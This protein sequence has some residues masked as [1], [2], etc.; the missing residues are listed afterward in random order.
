MIWVQHVLTYLLIFSGLV[1]GLQFSIANVVLMDH[2]NINHQESRHDLLKA[3]YSDTL[4]LALDPRKQDNV[5]KGRKTLWFNAGI[6]QLHLP[7][8]PQAQ[9][10]NGVVT[11]AYENDDAMLK[12]RKRL[13][14][15]SSSY[16]LKSTQFEWAAEGDEFIIKDPWGGVFKAVVDPDAVDIRGVQPGAVVVTQLTQPRPKFAMAELIHFCDGVYVGPTS[17]PVGISDICIHVPVGCNLE[18]IGRFYEYTFATPSLRLWEMGDHPMISIV[19]S[20]QQTLTFKACAKAS[21]VLAQAEKE[22][23]RDASGKITVNHGPHV[24]LY[25]KDLPSSYWQAE[26]LGVLFVNNRFKRRAYTLED[27]VDQCMYRCLHVVDPADPAAGPIL[28]LEHEVRSI[29]TRDGSM[30]KSCPLTKVP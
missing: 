8:A 22:V 6:T 19:T 4:G 15:A 10:L 2:L 30:Y 1:K 21:D 25:L 12:L 11:L 24:S 28:Q 14:V 7:E 13:E 9:K 16:V 29:T 5:E 18:G 17:A 27:A 20:P 3:F 26:K 23:E